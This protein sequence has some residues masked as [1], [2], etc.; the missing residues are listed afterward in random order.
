[1]KEVTIVGA[2]LAGSEAAFFLL[3]KGYKVHLYERRPLVDDGAHTTDAFGELVCSNSLKSDRLDNACG[4]LKEEM[5]KMDSITMEAAEIARVPGGNALAVDRDIFASKI[6][7]KLTSFPN[8]VLHRE[9]ITELPKGPTI[10]ATGPLML[11]IQE[12]PRSRGQ[13]CGYRSP[14]CR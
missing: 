14:C 9:E 4:L 10:I 11:P 2:G 1:M 6:T 8:L 3:K 13:G 5:R 7:A 12:P